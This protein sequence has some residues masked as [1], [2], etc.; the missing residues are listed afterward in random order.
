MARRTMS[1]TELRAKNKDK[2]GEGGQIAKLKVLIIEI[3]KEEK[4]ANFDFILRKLSGEKGLVY[5]DILENQVLAILK[6]KNWEELKR[7][8]DSKGGT[9]RYSLE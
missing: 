4:E 9:T 5:S 6:D 2:Y 1:I 8:K 7:E 3:L